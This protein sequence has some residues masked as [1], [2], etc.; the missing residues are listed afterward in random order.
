MRA[1]VWISVSLGLAMV[2][3]A[4]GT[5]LAQ[6]ATAPRSQPSS[7][8]ADAG[9]PVATPASGAGDGAAPVVAPASGG[10]ALAAEEA[11][12]E[13]VTTPEALPSA[14]ESPAEAA[15]Q[16]ADS[17]FGDEVPLEEPEGV[18][19]EE[20][21]AG[22]GGPSPWVWATA[23]V[24]AGSLVTGTIFGFLALNEESAFHETPTEAIAD[25]GETYALVADA[26]FALAVVSGVTAIVLHFTS[27]DREEEED[28]GADV[29]IAPV[30]GPGTGGVTARVRF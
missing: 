23:G 19:E 4:G 16:D 9:S 5:V 13:G 8:A 7:A 3:P 15:Q 11:A 24:A 10:E 30:V 1:G 28:A 20:G 27:D 14:A 26:F 18:A 2:A 29:A 6:E 22:T 21:D 17:P 12:S 25:R